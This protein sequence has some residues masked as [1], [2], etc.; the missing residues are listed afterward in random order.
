[1]IDIRAPEE[2]DIQALTELVNCPGV[3]WGAD[4]LPCTPR[5]WVEAQ[6]MRQDANAHPIVAE[7][8]GRAIGWAAL[9]QKPGRSRHVGSLGISVHDDFQG[10]GI[11]RAMTAALIDLADNWLGLT[12]LEL[13]VFTDNDPAI[14]L[15][16]AFGFVIEGTSRAV[17]LRDGQLIDSHL[18]GRLKPEQQQKST[19]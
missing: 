5:S 16:R 15:Y 6:V 19:A 12:R 3:R 9:R 13:S 10:R 7:V 8:E 2:R 18:M 17:F 11:G 4:R 14:S 1:M